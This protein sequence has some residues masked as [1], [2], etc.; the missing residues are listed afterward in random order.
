MQDLK[1]AALTEAGADSAAGGLEAL[2]DGTGDFSDFFQL[3]LTGSNASKGTDSKQTEERMVAAPMKDTPTRLENDTTSLFQSLSAFRAGGGDGGAGDVDDDHGEDI[4]A[5][6]GLPS[7]SGHK[8]QRQLRQEKEEGNDRNLHRRDGG[9]RGGILDGL[10]ERERGEGP[11]FDTEQSD[12]ARMQKQFEDM[13]KS[14]L[15]E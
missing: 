10:R 2:Y 3:E 14:F 12:W 6:L 8:R 7:T 13:N 11:S 4:L 5:S 15:Q 9:A 1:D